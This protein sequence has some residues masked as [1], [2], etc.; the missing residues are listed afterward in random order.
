MKVLTQSLSNKK[1]QWEYTDV[2]WSGKRIWKAFVGDC[3]GKK[4]KRAGT[5]VSQLSIKIRFLKMT[6]SFH[7]I[8]RQWSE[9]S[10]ERCALAAWLEQSVFLALEAGDWLFQLCLHGSFFCITVLLLAGTSSVQLKRFVWWSPSVWLL[11][12][13][14]RPHSLQTM[15]YN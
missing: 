5:I 13:S 9:S 14:C 8:G 2:G 11:K 1:H 12:T 6:T 4:K 3:W 10:A 7:P 15:M